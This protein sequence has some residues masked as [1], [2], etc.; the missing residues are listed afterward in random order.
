MF[1]D[2]ISS[3]VNI[4]SKS[5]KTGIFWLLLSL[6]IWL[7]GVG[8]R[9]LYALPGLIGF[10]LLLLEVRQNYKLSLSFNFLLTL[11]IHFFVI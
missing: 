2:F 8:G 11:R 7:L 3:V 10:I 4:V 9:D 5:W 1:F 6:F